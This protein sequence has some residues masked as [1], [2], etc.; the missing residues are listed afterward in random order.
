QKFRFL[1]I[2]LSTAGGG[3]SVSYSYWDGSNWK[4]F[5]PSGGDYYYN[6]ADKDLLLWDDFS[7]APQDWQK[8]VIDGTTLFW[9]KVEVVSGF[10][11][12]PIGSQITAISEIQA[13]SIRR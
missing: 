6:A 11:T 2:I 3:G 9:V 7:G 12:A 13:L 8:N 10:S 4:G 5:T 1:K